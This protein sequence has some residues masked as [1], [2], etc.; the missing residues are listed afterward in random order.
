MPFSSLV[1]RFSSFEVMP[2]ALSDFLASLSCNMSLKTLGTI[3]HDTPNLSFN[4]PHCS[5]SPPSE[6]FSHK[7]SSS[8]CV[9][10]LTKNDMAGENF[11]TG[12]PFNAM[13][14][15]SS[16][17]KVTVITVPSSLPEASAADS[18]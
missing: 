13:N 2:P 5:F 11:K 12:T 14:C 4:Q 7:S 10:Q 17:S 15:C 8:S 6:S 18:P 3:C 9:S 1:C 16:S